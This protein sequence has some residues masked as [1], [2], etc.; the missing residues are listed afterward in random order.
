[1]IA[2]VNGPRSTVLSGEPA[3]LEQL[4]AEWSR[5]GVFCRKLAVDV[6]AHS[7]QLDELLPGLEQELVGLQPQAG[8]LPFYSTVT[9]QLMA[10]DDL[11]G[12]YWARNLRAPVQLWGAVQSLVA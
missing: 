4:L 3:A 2:G 1:S 8:G 10:G 9:G 5:Q 11:D 12:A 6:A 7:P